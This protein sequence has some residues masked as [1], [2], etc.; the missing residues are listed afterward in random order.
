MDSRLENS[1]VPRA[2][3]NLAANSLWMTLSRFAAQGLTVVFTVVV[4]RRLGIAGFGEYAFIAA[5]IYV[6]NSLTTFGT[7]MVLIRQIA[8][9]G[10]LSGLP[11]ALLLQLVLSATLIVAVLFFGPGIPK[12]S[13]VAVQALRIYVLSL[14]PLAFFTIFS[15]ALRGLQRLDLYALL[16]LIVPALQVCIVLLPGMNLTVLSGLLL[17]VQVVAAIIAGLLCSALL[18]QLWSLRSTAVAGLRRLVP[19]CAPLVLLTVLGMGYQRLSIYML[20]TMADPSSTGLFSAAARAVEASKTAH[21]AVLAALYPAMALAGNQVAQQ[22]GLKK[23]IRISRN[24]LLAGGAAAAYVLSAFAGPLVRLLYGSDFQSSAPI[25]RVLAWTLIPFTVN[26]YLTLSLVASN[27][28][29]LVARAL[30]VSLFALFILNLWQIP[31]AGAVGS[32]WS[33][34]GAECLQAA[35]LLMSVRHQSVSKGVAREL[36]HL[37]G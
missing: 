22:A 1:V 4:A 34:L 20:S 23:N 35:V 33:A 6:A 32:A 8:A 31:A 5:L 10:D 18:P 19:A 37:P 30:I 12:Q 15:T 24:F 3:S 16:N 7:D 11:A 29:W 17:V 28:E 13:A 21:V 27:R 25:L 2:A 36:P 9:R 14:I 26:S